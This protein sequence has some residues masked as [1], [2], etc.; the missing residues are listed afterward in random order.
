MVVRVVR[1]ASA[2]RVARGEVALLVEVRQ[3]EVV[4]REAATGAAALRVA[5]SQAAA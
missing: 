2:A 4:W 3:E 5:A 1:A